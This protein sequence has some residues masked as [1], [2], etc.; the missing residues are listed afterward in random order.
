A[1]YL[2]LRHADTNLFPKY[3]GSPEWLN[4]VDITEP[5]RHGWGPL[6]LVIYVA[7]QLTSSWYMSTTM[8]GAQRY[9]LLILPIVFVPSLINFPS[10]LMISWLATNRW[11][12]GQGLIT[13]RMIPKPETPA[14]RSS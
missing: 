9:L 7:R 5:V 1:L 3:G 11:T 10:G 12:T 2:V 4:L 14:K 13:R 8:Q 6:L